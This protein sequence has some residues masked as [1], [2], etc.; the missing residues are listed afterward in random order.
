MTMNAYDDLKHLLRKTDKTQ[1]FLATGSTIC[2]MING[3]DKETAIA[4]AVEERW[5]APNDILNVEYILGD[6]PE[7]GSQYV[8]PCE[9]AWQEYCADDDDFGV[10][11]FQKGC[12]FL[13]FKAGWNA[14]G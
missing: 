7:I 12:E 3:E 8:D 13:I 6:H 11:E 10:T 4:K 5:L 9:A 1:P 14:R 2:R